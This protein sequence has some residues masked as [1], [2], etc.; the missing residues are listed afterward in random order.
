[1]AIKLLSCLTILP[2]SSHTNSPRIIVLFLTSLLKRRKRTR[3]LL[4]SQEIVLFFMTRKIP[5]HL[6]QQTRKFR[7][8]GTNTPPSP[9][10]QPGNRNVMD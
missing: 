1:M 6:P 3:F 4:T 9:P 7:P 8:S 10:H 2:F 5:F